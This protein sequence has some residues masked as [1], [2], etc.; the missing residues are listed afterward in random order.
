MNARDRLVSEC[1]P[2]LVRAVELLCTF[3]DVN[4]EPRLWEVM[5]DASE[6]LGGLAHRDESLRKL[7]VAHLLEQFGRVHDLAPQMPITEA[8]A[9][10]TPSF[11]ATA[12]ALLSTS[13]LVGLRDWCPPH[14]LESLWEDLCY[15]VGSRSYTVEKLLPYFIACYSDYARPQAL[16]ALR[17]LA[18]DEQVVARISVDAALE[19]QLAAAALTQGL[20]LPHLSTHHWRREELDAFRSGIS[21]LD[22]YRL[23]AAIRIKQ[24]LDVP[25]GRD[26]PLNRE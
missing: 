14:E 10:D 23:H 12:R 20:S 1:N 15:I 19:A 13:G 24:A 25:S 17:A 9:L 11:V 6:L 8:S 21:L 3:I 2:D 16:D 7:V 22:E 5:D 18:V 26:T 4:G